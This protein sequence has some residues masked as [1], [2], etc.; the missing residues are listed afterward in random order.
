MTEAQART[1]ARRGR[2]RA[3]YA[4]RLFGDG[5]ALSAS[6]GISAVVGM[7]SWVIA[8]RLM[9]QAEVG[10]AS[11]FV[12][13]F[14]L[15]AGFAQMNLGAAL[16]R[17]LPRAGNDSA[18]LVLRC[19][20]VVVATGTAGAAICL[21]LP[22]SELIFK[23]STGST[24][25]SV[26][27]WLIFTAAVVA[28]VVLQIQDFAL[29]G[30]GRAWWATARNVV[31]AGLRLAILVALGSGLTAQGA[32]WSWL[33]PLV[34]GAV[35]LSTVLPRLHPRSA[36]VVGGGTLPARHEVLSFLG[37]TYV[38]TV[39]T[40]LLFNQ[41]PL[42]VTVRF[43]T[44]TGAAFFIAWQAVTVVEVIAIYFVNGLSSEVA[45]APERAAEL[46]RTTRRRL[47]LLF[48]PPLALGLLV[49]APALG[50]FGEGYSA[51]APALRVLL[52]GLAF[53]LVVVHALGVRQAVGQAM[54]FARLQ[55]VTTG[56]VVL[57][58]LVVPARV[59]GDA[60]SILLPVACAYFAVQFCS[61]VAVLYLD[62][63]TRH[64]RTASRSRSAIEAE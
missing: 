7:V 31:V 38:G 29:V 1:S 41:V 15:I 2:H 53:R 6:A 50:I 60:E 18:T 54:R 58:V 21:V 59:G 61:A 30:L 3:R 57:A 35:V 48:L 36:P 34:A 56:L 43:G 44:E 22:W 39:A 28:W 4:D 16:L 17:W 49:A 63:P 12:S 10:E 27:G 24:A 52:V 64:A 11:A 62:S 5:L 37:P 14:L 45:R 13:A 26:T 47:L 42:V 46:A 51:S 19:T 20:A 9:P 40:T 32:V 8:A 23:A 25:P 33:V 55:I